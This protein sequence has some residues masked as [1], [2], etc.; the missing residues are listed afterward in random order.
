MD[1]TI[2][3]SGNSL[4]HIDGFWMPARTTIRAKRVK[5][6]SEDNDPS[7]LIRNKPD[8]WSFLVIIGIFFM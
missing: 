7:E 1:I 4:I 5:S 8:T 3:K 6:E 2:R